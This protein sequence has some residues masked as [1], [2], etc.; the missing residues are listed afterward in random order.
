MQKTINDGFRA[1]W[2]ENAQF[3]GIMEILL[4]FVNT[5]FEINF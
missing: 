3:S 4:M 2:V 5:I 1:D